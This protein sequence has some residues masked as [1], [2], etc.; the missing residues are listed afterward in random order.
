MLDGR[1]GSGEQFAAVPRDYTRRGQGRVCCVHHEP[2]RLQSESPRNTY[3]RRVPRQLHPDRARGVSL[4]HIARWRTGVS[5][6]LQ[7]HLSTRKRCQPG[8]RDRTGSH[9]R[10]RRAAR[11]LHHRHQRCRPGWSRSHCRRALRSCNQL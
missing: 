11:R 4:E 10:N 2:V 1:S 6:A 3:S 5:G 7:G 8:P 9:Q